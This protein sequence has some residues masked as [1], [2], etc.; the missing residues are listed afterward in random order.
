MYIFKKN[1]NIT[2]QNVFEL[3]LRILFIYSIIFL[4]TS[5]AFML[6]D[7]RSKTL[8]IY[9]VVIFPPNCFV[10]LSDHTIL[11]FSVIFQPERV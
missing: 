6:S 5:A 3:C 9:P 8:W 10:L 4:V 7:I 11:L 2:C 1:K